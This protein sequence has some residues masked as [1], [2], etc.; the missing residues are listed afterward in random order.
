MSGS[1]EETRSLPPE[2]VAHSSAVWVIT[3]AAWQA[4]RLDVIRSPCMVLAHF[5]EGLEL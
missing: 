5:R 3:L 2:A 4:S 1:T